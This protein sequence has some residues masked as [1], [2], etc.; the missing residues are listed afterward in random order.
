MSSPSFSNFRELMDTWDSS[1]HLF[2]ENDLCMFFKKD[3]VLYGATEAGRITFA[4]MKNPESKEDKDWRKDASFVA[5]DL[6][7]TASG[8]KSMTVFGY[9]DASKAKVIGEEEAKK[10]LKVK[11]KN[12]PVIKDD[13]DQDRA[14][15]EK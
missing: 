3:G 9:E 4:R 11:G 13:D 1:S 14:I 7:K 2:A 15:G 10:E 12:M 8:E 5:Y 6:E